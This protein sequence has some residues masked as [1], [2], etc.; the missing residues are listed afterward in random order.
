MKV[1]KSQAQHVKETPEP[2][3]VDADR[4]LICQMAA[5]M[6]GTHTPKQA[7]E[8]AIAIIAEVDAAAEA[9]NEQSTTPIL[10]LK[11]PK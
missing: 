11:E 6:A 4:S 10:D 1:A 9:A 5:S 8:R 7:V 3:V 2:I